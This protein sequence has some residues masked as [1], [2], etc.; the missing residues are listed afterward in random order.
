MFDHIVLIEIE[1]QVGPCRMEK[2]VLFNSNKISTNEAARLART[3]E[4]NDNVL[5]IPKSQWLA[6]FRD[7]KEGETA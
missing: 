2:V 6:L 3:G 7:G 1:E 5:V 4:Y